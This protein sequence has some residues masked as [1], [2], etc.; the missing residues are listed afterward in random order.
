MARAPMMRESYG[1]DPRDYEDLLATES[2]PGMGSLMGGDAFSQSV[3]EDMLLGTGQQYEPGG[4]QAPPMFPESV[5][6]PFA[7]VDTGIGAGR[8]RSEDLNF[9]PGYS[10][11]DYIRNQVG[12]GNVQP[13]PI[14]SNIPDFV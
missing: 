4:V 3:V 5:P 10:V 1:T 9:R 11:S 8:G 13:E 12:A 7:G 2:Y 6:G 14:G